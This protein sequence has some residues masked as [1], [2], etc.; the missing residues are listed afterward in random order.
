MSQNMKVN[1]KYISA[2]DQVLA[3]FDSQHSKTP[4]QLAEIN[5]YQRIYLL[6]DNPIREE[7]PSTL[8]DDF[9]D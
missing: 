3:K 4:S 9:I 1:K 2:I 8:W 7:K 5:K 6:R